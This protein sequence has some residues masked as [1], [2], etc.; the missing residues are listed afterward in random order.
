MQRQISRIVAKCGGALQRLARLIS[1]DRDLQ[2]E[3]VRPFFAANGDKTLRLFYDLTPNSVVF[4]LGGYEGQWASDIFAMYRCTIH[5]FEPVELFAAQIE[6]RFAGN[7][8]VIVHAFGLAEETK[9]VAYALN[10]DATSMLKTGKSMGTMRLVKAA[11]FL[12]GEKIGQIDLMKINIEGGEYDLLDHLIDTRAV[13]RIV[14]IQVQFHD[15]L[16]DAERRM[17][18]IQRRLEDTHHLTYQFP[19]VWENWQL[20]GVCGTRPDVNLNA[21]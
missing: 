11:D 14:N 12:L 16:P 4:D 1:P 2:A 21:T 5:L 3:R 19:F 13:S 9:T 17:I 20:K 8:Y 10:G 18:A 7:P 15:I 6:R